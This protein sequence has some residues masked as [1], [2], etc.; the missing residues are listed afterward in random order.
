MTRPDV[1]YIFR[2]SF[3]PI[4][5]SYQKTLHP[6]SFCLAL[7]IVSYKKRRLLSQ[8]PYSNYSR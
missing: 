8:T 4:N 1:Y 2:K 3:H 7:S 5:V 6:L